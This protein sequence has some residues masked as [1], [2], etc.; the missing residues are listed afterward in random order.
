MKKMKC[1]MVATLMSVSAST[2]AGT[3][4]VESSSSSS[5]SLDIPVNIVV[6]Q[7]ITFKDGK[8]I[9]VYYQKAENVCKLYS[10][11]DITKYKESDLTNI[12]SSNFEIVDKVEG[13]C[14]VTHKTS[15]ILN[16]AK[17]VLGK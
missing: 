2:F 11:T 7:T 14:Y 3:T 5:I 9:A 4:T 17:A 13:K 6:K 16:M 10:E 12:K 8:T 1:F 15:D